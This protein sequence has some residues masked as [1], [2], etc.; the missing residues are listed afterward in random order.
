MPNGAFVLSMNVV[1]TNKNA[2]F[3]R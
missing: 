2:P 1:W 3:V